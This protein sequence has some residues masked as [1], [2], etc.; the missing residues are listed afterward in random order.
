MRSNNKPSINVNASDHFGTTLLHF[1]WRIQ[2]LPMLIG[3]QLLYEK[4][5]LMGFPKAEPDFNLQITRMYKISFQERDRNT[6]RDWYKETLN[7]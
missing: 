5:P 6:I 2:T 4:S 3:A 7:L 1:V